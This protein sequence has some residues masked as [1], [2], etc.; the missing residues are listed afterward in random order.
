MNPPFN[1]GNEGNSNF[2]PSP[3]L[4]S[5]SSDGV[6]LNT[7]DATAIA[8]SSMSFQSTP[9]Y[10]V[11]GYPQPSSSSS[12]GNTATSSS[13][14][15][16]QGQG[17]GVVSSSAPLMAPFAA[18]SAAYQ[19]SNA[20]T[21]PSN[22]G[23]DSYFVSNIQPILPAMP[24]LPSMSVIPSA[25]QVQRETERN[26]MNDLLKKVIVTYPLFYVFFSPSFFSSTSP[27]LCNSI[28]CTH[29]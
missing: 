15:F 5:F 16:G 7:Y 11:G 21:E 22:N 17:Q 18:A 13:F 14:A 3:Q 10:L 25:D 20:P 29:I 26:F 4:T 19:Y 9:S 24:Y 6:A 2:H 1:S 27:F 12:F 28:T 8:P 23:A